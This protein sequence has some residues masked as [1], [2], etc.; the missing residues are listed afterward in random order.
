MPT[1]LIAGIKNLGRTVALHFARR[2]WNVAVAS[3][4]RADVEALA[5]DVE[6]AGGKGLPVVAD[7]ADTANCAELVERTRARFGA[8]ELCVAS[9]TSGARF[10]PTPILEVTEDD[11]RRTFFGYPVNTLHLLQAVAR[12]QVAQ[13]G[14]TFVQMGTSS[15][16]R[17]R[18]GFAALGAAQHALRALLLAAAQELRGQLVH[19]AYV[20]IEGGI[21]SEKSQGHTARVGLDRTLPPD[22]IAKAI[23]YLHEQGPRSWTHELALKPARTEWSA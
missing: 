3:R 9:Q 18:Q 11:L 8:I 21:E 14:G 16:L 1:L 5:R 23:Q 17:P 10:G 22:E 15:G 7:L 19:V 12:Q 6:V 20:A 13:G 4:T 2:G